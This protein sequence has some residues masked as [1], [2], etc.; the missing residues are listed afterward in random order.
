MGRSLGWIHLAAAFALLCVAN[1]RWIVAPAAWLAPAVLLLFVDSRPPVRGLGLAWLA[2]LLAFSVSWREIIPVPGLWYYLVAGIY[3]LACF[4]P[5]VAHRLLAPGMAGWRATLVFPISWVAVELLFQ[6][7]A[8]PYGSWASPAYTQVGF[9]PLIQLAALTGVQGVHFLMGWVAAIAATAWRERRRPARVVPAAIACGLVVATVA[10][11]GQWRIESAPRDAPVARV[12]GLTPS[13]ELTHELQRALAAAEDGP[14]PAAVLEAAD[15]INDDLLARSR[16]QAEAGAE[17]IVWSE[18]AA[19]V[20][21]GSEPRFLDQARALAREAGVDLILG[22]GLWDPGARPSFENKAVLIDSGGK[23]RGVFHKA[24]PIVG[25]ESGVIGPGSASIATMD[26]ARGRFGVVI[27]HDLDFP[28]LLREAGRLEVEVLFAPAAD[29]A[30]ITP[31]HAHM[32]IPRALENGCSLVRPCSGGLS[33]VVDPQGRILASQL[34]PDGGS[35]LVTAGV[36]IYRRGVLYPVVGDALGWA[37]LAGLALV[38]LALVGPPPAR[39][40]LAPI[41]GQAP[42]D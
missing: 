35:G 41:V 29:W 3:A 36:P 4:L 6:K 33:L 20:T 10:A 34:D 2:Q 22:L 1:G 18:H 31:L 11:W 38:V 24:R 21:R 30:A 17:V 26:T 8:T 23:L 16:R 28:D 39:R 14:L 5:V 12:A 7:I 19:R 37:G 13:A 40:V 27:C 9:G 42:K 25:R 32:A 15:R